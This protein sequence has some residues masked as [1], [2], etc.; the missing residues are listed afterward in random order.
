MSDKLICNVEIRLASILYNR[1]CY[2][3]TILLK[4]MVPEYSQISPTAIFCARM[5]AK[6]NLPYS[7]ELI[8]LLDIKYFKFIEDLPDYNKAPF[9]KSYFIPFIEGRYYSL[10]EALRQTLRHTKNVLIVELASG[11][12]TRGLNFAGKNIFYMETDLKKLI[13]LKEKIVIDIIN[14]NRLNKSNHLFMS[15]NPLVKKDVDRIGKYYLKYFANNKMIIIHEGLMMYLNKKEKTIFRD[16][17]KYLF[18]KYACN[19]LWLSP[20]FSRTMNQFHG[21]KGK[22][23]IRDKI[24]KVTGRNFDYFKSL[25]E[26]SKFVKDG[27][28][29]SRIISNKKIVSQ[30]IRKKGFQFNYDAILKS[31]EEYRVWK[32]E[33]P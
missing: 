11:L 24:S 17:I 7:K 14:N 31:A 15:I 1:K 32:I 27:K 4:I 21:F 20:D 23:N 19:G 26:A 18:E 5:R 6:Q 10:N 3:D 33:L 2:I 22:E 16:N 9:H 13:R 8:N 29:K 25:K 30:L 12:S 28:L